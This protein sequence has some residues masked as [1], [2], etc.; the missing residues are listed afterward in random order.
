[1]S[2]STH[3]KLIFT[4]VVLYVD[5]KSWKSQEFFNLWNFE[6]EKDNVDRRHCGKNERGKGHA[7]T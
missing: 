2:E 5:G 7:A 3:K 1:M 6:I 4:T